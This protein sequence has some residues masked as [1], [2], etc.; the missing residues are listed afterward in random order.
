L[1]D[2]KSSYVIE[3]ERPPQDRIQRWGRAIGEAG[4][5][6]LDARD[7][8]RLQTIVIGDERFVKMGFRQ[9]G[10]V[11]GERDQDTLPIPDHIDA[12]HEDIGPLP[13][14]MISPGYS[15]LISPRIPR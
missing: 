12:R 11:V 14:P 13:I 10:G 8:L 1:K 5:A 6:P 15:D 7:F 2:S 9:E 3:G 4:R